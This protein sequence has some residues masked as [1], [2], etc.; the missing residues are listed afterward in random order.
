MRVWL[1]V[2]AVLFSSVATVSAQETGTITLKSAHSVSDTADRLV[3]AL[4]SKG[5]TVFARIDHAAG[6]AKTGQALA[7]TQL[8]IFGNPKVGTPLMKCN[9]AVAI[10]LPQKALI[11]EDGQQNVWFTYNAPAYLNARHNLDACKGVLSKISK[12]LGAFAKTATADQ[13]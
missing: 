2:L 7:P 11:W 3:S 13:P 5:M 10:D 1:S 9:R 12:A 4:E 8:V 6:A